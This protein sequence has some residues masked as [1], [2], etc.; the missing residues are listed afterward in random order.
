MIGT[1]LGRYRIVGRLGE[2]GMGVVW[3]ASDPRLDREVA[4]KLVREGALA[5]DSV[6]K[7][8]RIEARAL[9]RLLH[10]GIATLF[11]LDQDGEHE[12]LVMEYVPGGTLAEILDRGPLPE[13]RARAIG[14]E[15]ADALHSAHE[16]G[17]VH[18]DLKPRNVVITPN[19]HA[20]ILDFGLAQLV[21]SVD[22]TATVTASETPSLAGT[23][24]YMAPEQV[25][26][27]P[28]DARTDVHALGVLLFEMVAGRTPFAGDDPVSTLYRI[29]HEPA[30]SLAQT[31]PGV[32]RA[33]DALVARCL[34]KAPE[35]RFATAADAARE[36]RT[37]TT[38]RAV[39]AREES[40]GEGYRSLVVL[41]FEN[42]SGDSAQ[43]FFT[44][45][46]TDLLIN[47]LAQIGALRVIS[48]TSAMRF[49]G[50]GR[51]LADIARELN[52]RAVV[53]GS[54]MRVGDR[55]R[56]SVQLVDA[57]ADRGIWARSYDR[58][59][60]DILAL[61]SELASAIAKEIQV[62]VTPA[63]EVKL[64]PRGQVNPTAHVAYLRGR[65]LWNRWGADEVRES[66]AC[67]EEALRADPDYAPA[68]AGLA[69]AYT[70]LGTTRAMAP[71]EAYSRA[72]DAA[73]RGL[74][75][76]ETAAE[77]HSALGNV[78]RHHEWDWPGAEREFLRA[79]E[80][81]PGY[82]LG[83]DRYALLLS[84]LGRHDEAIAEVMRA[85][86]MDPL[87]LIIHTA[88]GDALF[89]ARRFEESMI[90][91]RRCNQMDPT[92]G[93]GNTDLAR[94]LEHVGRFEEALERFA[95]GVRRPDGSI[96]P[97]TGLA[98]MLWRA[99]RQ[100]EAR[101]TMEQVHEAAKTR[102]IAPF[103]IASFHAVAG[104]P[105]L[106]LDWLERA[107]AERDSS[108]VLLKVHPRLDS[109]RGEPRFR[110]LLEKLHLDA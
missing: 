14:A 98:I 91:Y 51:A 4:L 26:Q 13:A 30:P 24:P 20:K 61:Q 97:S 10:P 64:R 31:R 79:L 40:T 17:V 32:S 60:T 110:A 21:A 67:F 47:D 38:P 49:K 88:V 25:Q 3:R 35:R 52:V 45:G 48:R 41:P 9:S 12:F 77:L 89:Y 62:K 18:R 63:E 99:G 68:L 11:D 102:Y 101:G 57:I 46:L 76:D 108:L 16:R 93:P 75:L 5:D 104:E 78:L 109:L 74:A 73:T 55:V 84:N 29:V 106:A 92:F 28:L 85:L 34:E 7:R 105:G 37:A 39:A 70:T 69:D 15:I 23:V 50:G 90:Y 22:S 59:L 103:G 53:E 87:S 1:T 72:K 8:F 100:D 80:L 54:A 71:G 96:P 6:R 82:A 107:Y 36:L 94:S 56:V 43:E 42:R 19:G 86:E 2:G 95:N 81:N 83:R 33:L 27:R 44:D 66:I 58:D 65:F